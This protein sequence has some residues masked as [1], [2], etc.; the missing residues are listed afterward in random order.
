MLRNGP[1]IVRSSKIQKNPAAARKAGAAAKAVA[2]AV[3][4]ISNKFFEGLSSLG[5]KSDSTP[6][7][8]KTTF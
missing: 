1:G 4:A 5:P 7:S 8:I 2:V 3:A 6:T